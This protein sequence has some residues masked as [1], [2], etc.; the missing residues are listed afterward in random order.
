MDS[1]L[2]SYDDM[3]SRLAVL[4]IGHPMSCSRRTPVELLDHQF[5]TPPGIIFPIFKTLA[6]AGVHAWRACSNPRCQA[7][8]RAPPHPAAYLYS[9]ERKAGTCTHERAR[10]RCHCVKADAEHAEHTAHH[11]Q[12]AFCES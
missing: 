9:R 12:H 1:Q 5:Y 4:T 3:F 8:S 6:S 7:R 11:H 2:C 10:S